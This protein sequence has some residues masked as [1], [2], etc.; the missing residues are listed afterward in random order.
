MSQKSRQNRV[1]T[2]GVG[3]SSGAVLGAIAAVFLVAHSPQAAAPLLYTTLDDAASVL[4]PAV[5]TGTGAVI[6]TSPVNDFVPGETGNGI[7][8]DAASEHVRFQETDGTTKNVE[9]D[10]GTAEFWYKPNYAHTDGVFHNIFGI[11]DPN[12]PGRLRLY[13]AGSGMANDL[14]FEF[15]DAAGTWRYAAVKSMNYSWSAGQWIKVRVTWDS[16]SASGVQNAR[17]YLNDTEPV[18]G[19]V[20]TGPF[21]MPQESASQY[22]VLGNSYTNT[23]AHTT[24]VIDEFRIYE[25]ALP[26]LPPADT[27]SPSVSLTAPASGATLSG[28]EAIS[29]NASDNTGVSGVQFTLDG[30]PLGAEDTAAPYI[31]PWDTATVA[32]GSYALSAVARDTAGNIGVA[33]SVPVTVSN[34]GVSRFTFLAAGDY[35]STANTSLNLTGMASAGANFTLALGDFSY[36][37]QT[38]TQ[39]CNYI[40]SFFG[41]AYPFELLAGNHDET[42]IDTFASCLPDLL[43]NIT[44]AY[45]KEYYFDYPA[46]SPLARFILISP[47]LTINSAT[48]SYAST[49]PRYTWTSNA[50]DGARSAGI[51]WV[52][53]GM[54]KVCLSMGVKSCEIGVDLEN[55][56]VGKKVDLV[57]Q[58]HDHDYQ[59]SKQLALNPSSCPALVA[60]SYNANCTVP[61]GDGNPDTYVKGSG[62]VSVISGAGGFNNY[63]VNASDSEAG[64]FA[65]WYG[66]SANP[67]SG[68]AK[69][70]VS[71]DEISVSFVRTAG[72]SFADNFT[73][74][75]IPVIPDLTPPSAPANLSAIPVSSSRVD[76]SWSSSTDDVGVAGYRIFRDSVQIATTS[77]LAY[78]DAAGLTASTTYRYAVGAFDAAGNES[79]LSNEAS[80]TTFS[81]PPPPSGLLFLTTLD[82][83]ASVSSP[84]NGTGSGAVVNTSPANDFVA[85]QNING[86]R[87]DA[88]GEHVRFRETDGTMKNVELDVGTVEFWYKPNSAHAD[89]VLRNIFGI[90]D[91]SQPGRMRL[92]KSGNSVNELRFEIKDANSAWR[93]ASVPS[94]A[95]GWSAGQWVK[96]RV[97][98]DSQA[99]IGAQNI[100]IYLNDL[101]VSQYGMAPTGPFSMPAESA[102][103]YIVI[104]NNYIT[105]P[106]SA[107]GVFDEFRIYE[108]AITP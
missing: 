67:V 34:A 90:G 62:T 108:G 87:V 32:D 9:L 44:G 30:A 58:A 69:F 98:W 92:F 99:G 105:T 31:F 75:N 33:S 1:K 28:V 20:P 6:Q 19:T 74:T 81:P 40:K 27:I 35:N 17:I 45:G 47:N 29:A 36:D 42:N 11:G 71:P 85:G 95:Y 18:Y 48:Y 82:D 37:M 89:G 12:L 78:Q 97:T 5:G 104:G 61:D 56:L 21:S 88:M 14:R 63:D 59:R 84:A 26:P 66:S 16:Q 107:A 94:S 41:A 7:R 50:I 102:A 51:P 86:I 106:V 25:G 64:Y 80:A 91:P 79:A 77:A 93:Y 4:A 68:F 65:K 8:I 96:I 57:L 60:G 3:I 46:A 23:P 55:L 73:I 100:R 13:K 54:H 38:E 10:A 2:F 76:L 83:L 49:S 39:W 103:Q 101:E 24:G 52:V 15:R 53:V 70:D 43:G 22:I 72:A